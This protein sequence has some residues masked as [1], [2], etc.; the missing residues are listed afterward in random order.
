MKQIQTEFKTLLNLKRPSVFILTLPFLALFYIRM[1]ENGKHLTTIQSIIILFFFLIFDFLFLHFSKPKNKFFLIALVYSF[2]IMFYYYTYFLNL[3]VFLNVIT[4]NI[5]IKAKIIIPVLYLVLFYSFYKMNKIINNFLYVFNVFLI[6]LGLVLVINSIKKE[7]NLKKIKGHQISIQNLKKKSVILII[8][9]E[10]ASP[11]E[12]YNLKKDSSIFG[13]KKNLE[14]TNWI[15]KNKMY[16]FNILTIHS[17][18]SLF[19]FNYRK[20]DAE[21]NIAYSTYNLKK[22]SLY[23]SLIKKDIL[24]YNY[25]IFDIGKSKAMSKIYYKENEP[26]NTNIY[27]D[28]FFNTLL[29]PFMSFNKDEYKNV[30][31]HNQINVETKSKFINKLDGNVFIYLHLLLPHDPYEFHGINNFKLLPKNKERFNNY[32]RYWN[33]SN[34]LFATLLNDLTKSNKYRIILTGDH[35]YRGT[36]EIN[37]AYTFSAF[38]GFDST[39]INKITSVQDIGSLINSSYE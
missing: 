24:F 12:L 35:G 1:Y 10:Y 4:I 38:Y 33:F 32:F 5:N 15:T 31:I 21:L 17:L 2:L 20:V 9:D 18:A 39:S 37:P 11:N 22:S 6:I 19:N 36:R 23:D 8:A 34:K 14:K 26:G 3:I 29:I 13:F 27:K 30:I 16:S 7:L 28:I 25:G